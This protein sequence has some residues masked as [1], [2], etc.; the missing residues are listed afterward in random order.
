MPAAAPLTPDQQA[1][2]TAGLCGCGCGASLPREQLTRWHRPDFC[3]HCDSTGEKT[4][5]A[6]KAASHGYGSQCATE[7]CERYPSGGYVPNGEGAPVGRWS[8]GGKCRQRAYRQRIKAGTRRTKR[9]RQRT[10][11]LA[12]AARLDQE[13]QGAERRAKW[14]ATEALEK[15][16][17]AQSIRERWALEDGGQLPLAEAA[18]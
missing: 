7:D 3:A 10:A 1:Q 17:E 9:D 5:D 11:E 6:P 18:K 16:A 8:P 13:A 2:I 14:A 4:R 12:Q 15:A